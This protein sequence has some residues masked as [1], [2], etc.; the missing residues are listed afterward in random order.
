[1]VKQLVVLASL[2]V[3][4]GSAGMAMYLQNNPLAFSKKERVDLNT[5]LYS[6]RTLPPA[7][8]PVPD[9]PVAEPDAQIIELA[10][11]VALQTKRTTQNPACLRADYAT[12]LRLAHSSRQRLNE[13]LS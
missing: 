7:T 9:T 8:A 11:E 13:L 5:Y 12:G 3:G 4:T 6:A 2:L 1:M 10:P